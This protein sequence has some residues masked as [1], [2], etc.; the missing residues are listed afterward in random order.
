MD[1]VKQFVDNDR[2]AEEVSLHPKLATY[3]VSVQDDRGNRIALFQGTVY[4]KKEKLSGV[5]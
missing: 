5:E 1:E 2:L 4:R 3:L